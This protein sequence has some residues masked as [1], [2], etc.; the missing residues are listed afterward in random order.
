MLN[1]PWALSLYDVKYFAMLR[2]Q[3]IYPYF[4]SKM[5]ILNDQSIRHGKN[6]RVFVPSID[7]KKRYSWSVSVA[8][9]L[10]QESRNSRFADRASS[11]RNDL[12]LDG[13]HYSSVL[14]AFV[15][16]S[17]THKMKQQKIILL[18]LTLSVT[19]QGLSVSFWR[20]SY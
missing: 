17:V 6:V 20:H 18:I 19:F 12:N 9:S 7:G 4:L 5:P 8:S 11:P 2:E 3:T 13:I 10:F 14:S 1:N 16:H 15:C